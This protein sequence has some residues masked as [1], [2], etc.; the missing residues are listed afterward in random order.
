MQAGPGGARARSGQAARL[1]IYRIK[2]PFTLRLLSP[3]LVDESNQISMSSAEPA[4]IPALMEE[5]V[6]EILIR[7]PPAEPENLVRA[8]LVCKPRCRLMTSSLAAAS[9]T[10]SVSFTAR[11][12]ILG[13]ICNRVDAI[14]T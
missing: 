8:A 5:I 3:L 13:L 11:P 7:L 6:K 4:P 1:A 10:A 9:A 12:P 14:L 2:H